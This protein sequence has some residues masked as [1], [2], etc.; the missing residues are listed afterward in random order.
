MDSKTVNIEEIMQEIRQEIKDRHLTPD[1]LSFED[2]PFQKPAETGA[3]GWDSEQTRSALLYVNGQYAVQPYK[4]LHGNPLFVFLKKVI[5]K[6]TKFYIEP[7]VSEQNAFNAN[8]VRLFNAIGKD[9]EN[10]GNAEE[11][12]HRLEVLELNQKLLSQRT[13]AL[14]AEN[15]ALRKKL[16][17]GA[18]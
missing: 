3:E 1:M 18:K 11:I 15:A 14:Q 17:D 12:L 13:E 10:A 9:R 8:A 5:R 16:E 2:V 7:I 6:L 4:E